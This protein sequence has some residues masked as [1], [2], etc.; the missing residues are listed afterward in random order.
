LFYPWRLLKRHYLLVSGQIW[1]LNLWKMH[2]VCRRR[3]AVVLVDSARELVLVYGQ[4]W[5]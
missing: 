5:T 3:K 4:S 2:V 1:L